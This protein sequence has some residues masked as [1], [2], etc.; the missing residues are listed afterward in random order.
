MSGKV[1]YNQMIQKQ[2]AALNRLQERLKEMREEYLTYQRMI[3]QMKE[4]LK[5]KVEEVQD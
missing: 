4:N 2:Q 5:N 1:D 3:E